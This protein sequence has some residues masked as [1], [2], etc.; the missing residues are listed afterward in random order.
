MSFSVRSNK[1]VSLPKEAQ[2]GQESS[3]KLGEYHMELINHGL[4]PE[5]FYNGENWVYSIPYNAENLVEKPAENLVEKPSENL[6]EKPAENLVE[7][8]TENLVEK[9]V[10]IQEN[11][12]IIINEMCNSFLRKYSTSQ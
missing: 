4:K 12:S 3:Q 8:P 5:L 11:S 2:L 7:K 10:M 1:A 9:P 6:V